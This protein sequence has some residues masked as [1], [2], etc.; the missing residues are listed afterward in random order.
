MDL[1]QPQPFSIDVL[2]S[3]GLVVRVRVTGAIDI[4]TAPELGRVLARALEPG[5]HLRLDLSAVWFLDSTG[6]RA[7]ANA[8]HKAHCT[9]GTFT[10]DSPLPQQARRIME[11]TGL[12]SLFQ[13]R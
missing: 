7:I 9:G 5:I 10:I 2:P 13:L 8:A 11:I 4:R 6:V 12:Q 1:L 3:E